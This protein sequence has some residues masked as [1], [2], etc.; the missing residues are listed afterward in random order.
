MALW[1]V[2]WLLQSTLW[3]L[4][5]ILYK[6]LLHG[7][8]SPFPS[9]SFS[10][11]ILH[12]VVVKNNYHHLWF[13]FLG[14]EDLYN[15]YV[16]TTNVEDMTKKLCMIQ[17]EEIVFEMFKPFCHLS[18]KGLRRRGCP[19]WLG[20]WFVI[21]HPLVRIDKLLALV[22]TK[23]YTTARFTCVMLA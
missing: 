9:L 10:L 22:G 3:L 1:L 4:L 12:V 13:P 8:P 7:F 14:L 2:T 23:M 6:V 11:Q 17:Y 15:N 5:L 16:K 18:Q 20:H 19:W 21:W